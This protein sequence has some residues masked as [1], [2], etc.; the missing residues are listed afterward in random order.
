MHGM[1][2][3]ILKYYHFSGLSQPLVNGSVITPEVET[4]SPS[5][6][7]SSSPTEPAGPSP[8][9]PSQSLTVAPTFQ[10]LLSDD[11][12][13]SLMAEPE[14]ESKEPDGTPIRNSFNL[15]R[16]REASKNTKNVCPLMFYFST[17]LSG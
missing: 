6:P 11:L 8:P 4:P 14:P 5:P 10:D 7:P 16:L 2:L 9:S 17:D 12:V 1:N 3:R 15:L 13:Y